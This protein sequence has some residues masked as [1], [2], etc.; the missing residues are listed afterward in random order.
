MSPVIGTIHVPTWTQGTAVPTGGQHGDFYLRT[1]TS[2]VYQNING[3]WTIVDNL[4]GLT[5]NT[6]NTGGML[7]PFSVFGNV[8]VSTY[9]FRWYAPATMTI[10]SVRASVGTAPTGA[11]LIVD[12]NKN[13]TTIFTTQGNRPSIAASGFTAT[14]TPDVT[15]LT[16][17]DYLTVDVDQVGS[18]IPGANLSVQV[19]L[20]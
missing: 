9:S 6:G 7:L 17:G 15:S 3:T 18:T 20:V 10:S 19:A 4:V 2:D 5:G 11:A 8:I 1:T 12:V 13:G 16:A 14:G